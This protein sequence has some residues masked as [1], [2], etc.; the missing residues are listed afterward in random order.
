MIHVYGSVVAG[1]GGGIP[2]ELSPVRQAGLVS[3]RETPWGPHCGQYN[4]PIPQ[5]L[6]NVS[7]SRTNRGKCNQ[8]RDLRVEKDK[9]SQFTNNL[10]M[11]KTPI[12]AL[13]LAP[14]YLSTHNDL[15]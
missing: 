12:K 7:M 4:L 11:I 9:A 6:V 13:S 14:V 5:H 3:V 1:N 8:T 10:H 15:N 2:R